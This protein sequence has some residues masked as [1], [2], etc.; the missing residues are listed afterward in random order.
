MKY[1]KI[2]SKKYLIR[3]ERG[4]EIIGSIL[5]FSK[6]MTIPFS[7]LSGIGAISQMTIAF[8]NLKDKKYIDRNCNEPFEIV[9]LSGN[10]SNFNNQPIAHL[11]IVAANQNFQVIGGH[12]KSATVAATLEIII[13]TCDKII[14]RFPDQKTGLNLI[15]V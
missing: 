4:E 8:Y 11:H 1:Q 14:N 2:G 9:S 13:E 7:F 6:K 12:L 5:E 3:L 15:E 10:L